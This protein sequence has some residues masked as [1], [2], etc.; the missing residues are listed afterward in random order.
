VSSM[1]SIIGGGLILLSALGCGTRTSDGARSAET[2]MVLP[3]IQERL[4][5]RVVTGTLVRQN[6]SEYVVREAEGSVE[7]TVRVDQR[8]KLDP[9]TAGETVRIYIT[10][11]GRATTLQR[12]PK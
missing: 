12:I 4:S 1:R 2:G 7:R 3:T 5:Q 6:G 9:V 10:E 11:D 8:T